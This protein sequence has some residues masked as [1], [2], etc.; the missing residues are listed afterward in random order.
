MRKRLRSRNASS[1][2]RADALRLLIVSRD[3]GEY[4]VVIV[5]GVSIW[6]SSMT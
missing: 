4:E 1:L 3:E 2:R 6:L 5:S